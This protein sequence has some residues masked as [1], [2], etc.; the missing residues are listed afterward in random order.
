MQA[1]ANILTSSTT[2]DTKVHKGISLNT[3]VVSFIGSMLDV[4]LA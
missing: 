1:Q 3:L 4:F 2:K